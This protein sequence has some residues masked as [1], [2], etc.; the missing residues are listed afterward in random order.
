MPSRN[1][2]GQRL[3][4]KTRR[5]IREAVATWFAHAF[6]G[7][8]ADR[9]QI[10]PR[11]RGRW[12]ATTGVAVEEVEE[13]WAYCTAAEFNTHRPGLVRLAEQVARDG[14]QDAIAIL[15][16]SGMELVVREETS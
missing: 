12:G 7:S 9:T 2:H 10:R 3:P 13:V 5:V 1:R 16:D 8:T 4:G 11:L 6:A 15:V 14:D